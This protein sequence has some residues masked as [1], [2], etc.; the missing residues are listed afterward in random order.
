MSKDVSLRD[1]Y[2]AIKEFREEVRE[3]YVTKDEFVPVKMIAFG[4]VG[5]I[6]TLVLGA[7]LTGI[8]KA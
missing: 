3:T 6:V 8:I 2:D 7:I 1:I 5:T 4:L